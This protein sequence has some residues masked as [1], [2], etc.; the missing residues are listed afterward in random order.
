MKN[1]RKNGTIGENIAVEYLKEKGYHILQRNYRYDRGEIDIIA[2]D[3]NVLV[4]VEVKAR[5]S[6]Q[7]G[8]PEDAVTPQK[9]K[10][11]RATADGYLFEHNIDDKICR[12]DVLAITYERN[13]VLIR[14]IIEA[15]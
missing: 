2:E 4:F 10:K 15:F 14:H 8:E 7:Y 13:E 9:R 12:F 5:R 1:K 3:S 11:I 6:K